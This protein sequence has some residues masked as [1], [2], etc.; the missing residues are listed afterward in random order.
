ML[1]PMGWRRTGRRCCRLACPT[2]PEPWTSNSCPTPLPHCG[3][4]ACETMAAILTMSLS[5][6]CPPSFQTVPITNLTGR[7]KKVLGSSGYCWGMCA[8]GTK[9]LSTV[10]GPTRVGTRAMQRT[11]A[12]LPPPSRALHRHADGWL[13]ARLSTV[14]RHASVPKP[15]MATVGRVLEA[16]VRRRERH[17]CQAKVGQCELGARER[18]RPRI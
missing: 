2:Y 3:N 1:M 12:H 6:A 9:Q 17:Q 10:A 5:T 13:Q 16:G 11:R 7:E 18:S 15:R 8:A 14:R 4:T